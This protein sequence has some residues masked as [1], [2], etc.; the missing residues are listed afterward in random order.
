MTKKRGG[1][2]ESTSTSHLERRIAS[3]YHNTNKFQ[4][5]ANVSEQ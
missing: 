3:H 1:G 2:T 5:F 4:G